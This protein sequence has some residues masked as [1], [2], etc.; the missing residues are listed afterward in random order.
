MKTRKFLLIAVLIGALAIMSFGAV[1][2]QEPVTIQWWTIF[3]T[4]PELPALAE[5]LAQD[6]MDA[7][8]NVTIEITHLLS[9][10][11]I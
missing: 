11:H 9:L 3:T 10:I 6:Y 7:N 4:P 5:T 8:P 2:A 1:S